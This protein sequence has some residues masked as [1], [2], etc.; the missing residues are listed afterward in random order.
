[1]PLIFSYGTLQQ[2]NVQRATFGRLLLGHHDELPRFEP[3][4][5]RIVDATIVATSGK[6][7]HANARFNGRHDSRVSGMV[8][9]ITKAELASADRY[10][11]LAGYTRLAVTLAS[12]TEAWVYVHAD[13]APVAQAPMRIETPRLV[14]SP[15]QADDAE[16]IFDRYASDPEATRFLGWPRHRTLDDTRAFLSFSAQ[17]WER[18]PAGPYLIW[19]RDDGRLLGATGFG[20]DAPDH[21][22]TGYV[23]AQDA[24]GKGFATEALTAIVDLAG[25]I[26]V[27]RLTAQCHLGHRASR[28]VLE[29]CGFVHD[30]TWSQQIEFPNLAPGVPQ[31]AVRYELAVSVTRR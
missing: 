28:H 7:H 21:A 6:T 23:L 27:R 5:V 15:P 4:L 18:W 17:E 9:E 12:G 1:M 10:E 3:S 8:F 25:G 31:D 2:E 11:Q 29:K 19:S 30:A 13:S 22:V 14:L 20:F 26:G 24:W 16:A